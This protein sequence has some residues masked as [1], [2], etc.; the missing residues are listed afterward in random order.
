MNKLAL[1]SV[2]TAM[3]IQATGCI[4]ETR[5]DD[6]FPPDPPIEVATI[7]SSWALRN[8]SDGA[9]TQCPSGFESVQMFMQAVDPDG[10]PV[11]QPA[12]DVFDCD[13]F[14]GVAT[15]LY[16]DVY[17]TWIELRSF[18]LRTLYAQSLSQILD[19]RDD[20]K[21]FETELL[22]DGGYFMLQ[23][24]LIGADT[25][26]K[27]TC[28]QLAL[29]KIQTVSTRIATPN[30]AYDDS[31]ACND[32]FA[33]SAGLLEGSYDIQID[34]FSGNTAVGPGPLLTARPIRRQNEV[35]DLGM[36]LIPIEN[37]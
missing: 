31:F 27:L 8:M 35:T 5:D 4:I 13:T 1:A 22:N 36:V 2:M 19:V 28:D 25:N 17:Q 23:W 3:M 18:D 20:D 15:D 9:S 14:R 6:D 11:G 30:F 24:D 34:A 12:M 29:D 10:T 26:R 7:S 33:V 32:H 37:M 16:P 21:K